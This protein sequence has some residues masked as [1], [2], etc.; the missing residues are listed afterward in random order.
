MDDHI[1]FT[2][3]GHF[4]APSFRAFAIHR[5]GRLGL[6]L[7]MGECT[8]TACRLA[9]SGQV[10]LI[11]AFEMAMSLGPIDCVVLDVERQAV[12]ALWAMA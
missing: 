3:H 1:R 2:F 10:D 6:D 5:A 12:P 4:D 11:D 7:T 9:V 8:R